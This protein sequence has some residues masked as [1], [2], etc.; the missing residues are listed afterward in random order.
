MWKPEVGTFVWYVS[1]SSKWPRN[2]SIYRVK[3]LNKL[4]DTEEDVYVVCKCGSVNHFEAWSAQL[5]ETLEAAKEV[6][7]NRVDFGSG[8]YE[9]V[10]LGARLIRKP[11]TQTPS[12]EN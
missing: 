2:R 1:N 11:G 6:I 12:N 9:W 10:S 3:V 5:F 4:E 7:E 8:N